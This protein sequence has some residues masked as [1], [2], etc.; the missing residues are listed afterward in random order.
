MD[1]TFT[2]TPRLEAFRQEVRDW[3]D[4]E[5]PDEYRGFDWD[6]DEDPDHWAFYRQLWTKQGEKKWLEPTWPAE[7]NGAEM[8]ARQARILREEFAA[9]RVGGIAGIGMAVGP[10]IVRLGTDEQ[11]RFFL[12]KMGA[13]EIMW[14]EGYTEPNSGSDLASLRTR[15]VQDGDEWVITGQKTFCTAGHHCNWIIIAARTD[16]DPAKRHKGISYFLSPMDVPEIELRP[17]YNLGGGRQN[18]VFIDELRVPADMMLGDLNQGWTQIWFGIGGNPIPQFPD[19]DPGPDTE[20]EP[21]LSGQ[22]W[23]L[24][25]LTRY[26]RETVR[27]GRPMIDDPL[28]RN[29]L[30]RLAIGVEIE[31]ML[32]D[33][34]D[35]RYG[36][37]MHQGIT[38]EFQPEFAQ[39][40]MEIVGPLAQI[41]GGEWAPLAGE[42]DRIYR[43]SFGNHAGGT[44]QVKRMVVATRALGLPR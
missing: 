14:A 44:S 38:T 32:R 8:S 30:A 23:V 37:H 16:P 24:A 6:F 28:V 25:E 9:A 3:I 29:A 19:T 26:C 34:P 41:Q 5:V 42:I 13:G 33:E 1:I 39:I 11:K 35:C 43:R 36:T 21:P 22:A 15:A 4:A 10:C 17:L 40:C 7:W 27:H 12:P 31:K 20:Y 18:L 2:T